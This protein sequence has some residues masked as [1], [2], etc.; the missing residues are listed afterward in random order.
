MDDDAV[1][2]L[3]VKSADVS[4]DDDVSVVESEVVLADSVLVPPCGAL[5]FLY[6]SIY[7]F[8]FV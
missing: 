3:V 1:L 5:I 7:V 2:S 8:V 4:A 6:L